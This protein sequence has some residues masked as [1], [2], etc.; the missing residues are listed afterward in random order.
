M[1]AYSF[2]AV[3][4][5]ILILLASG[6]MA[7]AWMA[8]LRYRHWAFRK[9]LLISWLLVLPEYVL[10][11]WATRWG[12]GHYTGAEMAALHLSGGVVFVALLS[13]FLLDEALTR[14]QV[15]GFALMAVAIAIVLWP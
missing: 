5:P 8:H 2:S 1:I 6:V 10:N 14:R 15:V 3:L 13:H 4:V 9:A 7:L 11:V 12:H